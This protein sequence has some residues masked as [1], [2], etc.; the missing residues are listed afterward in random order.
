M[1]AAL[2]VALKNGPAAAVLVGYRSTQICALLTPC[3]RP[4]LNA[5]I[6]QLHMRRCTTRKP[7]EPPVRIELESAVLAPEIKIEIPARAGSA[8]SAL[9]VVQPP[10]HIVGGRL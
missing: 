10:A 7:D 6:C 1:A 2:R 8:L 4:I 5:T 9:T 3:R